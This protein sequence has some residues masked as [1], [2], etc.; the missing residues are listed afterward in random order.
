[1]VRVSVL[2]MIVLLSI[3]SGAMAQIDLQF[4]NWDLGL[5]TQVDLSNGTSA[6]TM[7]QGLQAAEIQNLTF[8]GSGNAGAATVGDTPGLAGIELPDGWGGLA[9][10]NGLPLL[11]QPAPESSLFGN[12][13]SLGLVQLSGP[14]LAVVGS[15]TPETPALGLS[16]I[17][18]W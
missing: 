15:P 2:S 12:G 10:M 8:G 14:S 11:G 9:G 13:L 7:A 6:A 5:N 3:G 4:Q 17:T 1:M 18:M 16:S